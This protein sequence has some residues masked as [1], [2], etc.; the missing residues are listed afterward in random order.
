IPHIFE[1]FHQVDHPSVKA[2]GGSGVGLSLVRECMTIHRGRISVESRLGAGSRF[3][4]ALPWAR[5]HYHPEEIT[6]G[7][8]AEPV[9]TGGDIG[10]DAVTLQRGSPKAF[11]AA[12]GEANSPGPPL[13]AALAPN[14]AESVRTI[15]GKYP[16]EPILIVDDEVDLLENYRMQLE[17]SGIDNLIL[18]RDGKAVLPLLRKQEVSIIILDLSLPG[19][20]GKRLLEQVRENHPANHV[21]VITG[22][23]D[24]A[25]AV[26]CMKLGAFDYMVKPVEL[27]HMLAKIEH[28]LDKR[29]LEKQ[30]DAL[31]Q[32]IQ[33]AE[34]RHPEAFAEIIT[35][36]KTML[37]RFRY[38]EAIAESNNP[39]LITG[40]SGVGKELIARAIHRLS[41]RTGTFVCENIAGLDDTMIS[42]ALFGHAKGA[43]TDAEGVRRGLVEE[44]AGGTL[45]LDEI[46]DLSG[47][48]QV[49]LLRFIEQNEYRPLG[50]DKVRVSDARII[51]ATN[52]NLK[53]KLE[54]GTFRK[55]LFYRL[56]H[57]I[58]VP[59][60]RERRND[61]PHLV[62]HFASRAAEALHFKTPAVPEELLPLLQSY[63]FPGNVRELKNMIENAVSRTQAKSLPISFFK[64]YLVT[65]RGG[66]ESRAP[67]IQ[68]EGDLLPL[69]ERLLKLRELE[70]YAVAEALKRSRGNQNIAARLLGLSPSALSRR[71]KKM[72]G[73]KG[74]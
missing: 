56:T 49:K 72:G 51:I 67:D 52:A 33:S 19:V 36:D 26:E 8:L 48:S 66:E 40:E 32:K 3:T 12:D 68:A 5:E 55:D 63:D 25:L 27:S 29:N 11:V 74:W 57:Q 7:E 1:R 54:A 53:E 38:I 22:L 18:C 16:D 17:D 34:L 42:D 30:I 21:L 44:A 24:V 41:N 23:Q 47:G 4:V 59:P 6:P 39:V 2:T 10:Y 70:E 35:R 15:S 50:A 14:P 73:K 37:S 58:H 20:S 9:E 43:F 71:I 60:L 61:L 28:C 13:Q 46:G 64:E 31:S 45:F 65:S 69:P 62:E